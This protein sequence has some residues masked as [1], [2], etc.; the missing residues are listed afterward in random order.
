MTIVSEPPPSAP[1]LSVDRPSRA[2]MTAFVAPAKRGILGRQIA[3]FEV[4]DEASPSKEPGIIRKLQ[5]QEIGFVVGPTGSSQSLA[6]LASTRD[7]TDKAS[8]FSS[9]EAAII[10]F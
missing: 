4:D 5:E 6:S 1:P 9:R 7:A 2:S 3:K 8:G 10:R